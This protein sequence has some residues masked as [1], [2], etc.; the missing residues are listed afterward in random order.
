M[1][2][3]ALLLA[4]ADYSAFLICSC[5]FSM[6]VS[7]PGFLSGAVLRTENH[8]R[9]SVAS[10]ISKLVSAGWHKARTIRL[11]MQSAM[12]LVGTLMPM[13]HR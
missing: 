6:D 7:D 12:Y 3:E 9:A 4:R 13:R 5:L 11:E 2:S 1:R 10:T 8:P